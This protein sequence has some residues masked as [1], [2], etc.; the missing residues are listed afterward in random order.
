MV[1]VAEADLE[2][3]ASL[4]AVIVALVLEVTVGAV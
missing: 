4:V 1:T 3:L 2:V